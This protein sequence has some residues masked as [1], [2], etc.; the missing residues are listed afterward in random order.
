[1][2]SFG[3]ARHVAS[4]T[5]CVWHLWFLSMVECLK[6][7]LSLAL[8]LSEHNTFESQHWKSHWEVF[9]FFVFALP[10]VLNLVKISRHSFLEASF[11][12][13]IRKM[14]I[15]SIGSSLPSDTLK[16]NDFD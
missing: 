14:G 8:V 7:G 6:G 13:M 1:M 5:G 9:L 3:L 11:L 12:S 15:K 16:G 10:T 2:I 4:N